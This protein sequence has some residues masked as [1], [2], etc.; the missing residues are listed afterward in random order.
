M[1]CFAL[2]HEERRPWIEPDALKTH[3]L[4]IAAQFHPDKI[5]TANPA[6]KS[7][8]NQRYAALNA[9]YQR[10]AD[11]KERLRHL[12]ELEKGA[13]VPDVQSV[14]HDAL[15]YMMEVGKVCHETDQFLAMRANAA[16]PL[17]KAQFFR[18]G[19]EWMDKLNGLRQRIDLRRETLLA[20]LK[21][22]NGSWRGS[23]PRLEQICRSLSF[24][25]R[26]SGQIQERLVQLSF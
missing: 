7:E 18:T 5:A 4:K 13:T 10:L 14:P 6:G 3:F 8:A 25:N 17:L 16:S 20:E 22:M 12:L 21:A 24:L 26:W 15:D 1:D 23:I 2:L 11:P 19:L 9:A